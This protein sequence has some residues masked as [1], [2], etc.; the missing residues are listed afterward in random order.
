M[1]NRRMHY[2]WVLNTLTGLIFA[3]NAHGDRCL[4]SPEERID[5]YTEKLDKELNLD[6]QQR[7]VLQGIAGAFNAK[8]AHMHGSRGQMPSQA[9]ALTEQ[10]RIVSGDV[11]DLVVKHR[12]ISD[13]IA[14]FVA[15]QFVRFH[16]VLRTEQRVRLAQLIE[17]YPFRRATLALRAVA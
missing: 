9:E 1:Q 6:G 4:C 3:G 2:N 12:P 13:V 10:E 16:N 14:A 11:P 7:R 17:D 5:L 8:I 15:D